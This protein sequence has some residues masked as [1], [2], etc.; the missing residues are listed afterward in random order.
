MNM[1][2]IM[3]AALKNLNWFRKKISNSD[4]IFHNAKLNELLGYVI[5]S[6]LDI[7]TH[8]EDFETLNILHF[9]V[10]DTSD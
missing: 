9:N 6:T 7:W 10:K 3:I 4:I 2:L 1:N 5:Y 8:N